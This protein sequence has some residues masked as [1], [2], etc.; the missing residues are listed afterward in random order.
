MSYKLYFSMKQTFDDFVNKLLG[1]FDFQNV[2]AWCG[3]RGAG[4]NPIFYENVLEIK[5]FSQ[6]AFAHIINIR[7]Y[8]CHAINSLDD[9]N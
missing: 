8:A 2:K 7:H 4:T 5:V 1:V 9:V 6:V 3:F